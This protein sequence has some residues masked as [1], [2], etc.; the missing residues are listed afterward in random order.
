MT[1]KDEYEKCLVAY[2]RGDPLATE[3]LARNCPSY[4]AELEDELKGSYEMYHRLEDE[5]EDICD[6]LTKAELQRDFYHKEYY[7][8]AE[9]VFDRWRPKVGHER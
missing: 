2:N 9:H 8:F 7:E 4:I 1:T 5:L 6:R 3:A